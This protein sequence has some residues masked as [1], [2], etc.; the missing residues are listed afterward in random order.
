MKNYI[1][2]LLLSILL[3]GCGNLFVSPV[4]ETPQVPA[5]ENS[6]VVTFNLG[7][8][9]EG[10]LAHTLLPDMSFSKYVLSFTALEEGKQPQEDLELEQGSSSRSVVLQTG[11]WRVRATGFNG[12]TPVA[13]GE[14]DINVAYS[15]YS[16][17][18]YI[19]V[20]QPL[21][22]QGTFTYSLVHGTGVSVSGQL[23]KFDGTGDPQVL[24]ESGTINP[25][26]AGMYKLDV[27]ANNGEKEVARTELVYIYKDVNT[28]A[29][30]VFSKAEFGATLYIGGTLAINGAGAYTGAAL[31]IWGD[32]AYTKSL[33][34]ATIT[35]TTW[36]KDLPTLNG[37]S[38]LYF[39][40][41]ITDAGGDFYANAG[42]IPAPVDDKNDIPLSVNYIVLSGTLDADYTVTAYEIYLYNADFSQRF[43]KAAVKSDGTWE[44][45]KQAFGESTACW[46]V[47]GTTQ[48]YSGGGYFYDSKVSRDV[49]AANISGI[50]L[51]IEP[52]DTVGVNGAWTDI[53]VPSNS[54]VFYRIVPENSGK[55]TLDIQYGN[56]GGSLTLYDGITHSYM[57]ALTGDSFYEHVVEKDHPYVVCA[58]S[59]GPFNGDDARFKLRFV[60]RKWVNLKGAAVV[61][62]DGQAP[63]SAEVEVYNAFTNALL[64][65]GPAAGGNWSARVLER[66]AE[67]PLYFVVRA[68]DS[69]G[70]EFAKKLEDS[71]YAVY[72][73][74]PGDIDF[75]NVAFDAIAL[76]GTV[77]PVTV[78]LALFNGAKII[79]KSGDTIL[80]TGGFI[81]ESASN[82]WSIKIPP[83]QSGTELNFE[84]S[85]SYSGYSRT[86][87]F[88]NTLIG[89]TTAGSSN[90]PGINL[91]IPIVGINQTI[92]RDIGNYNGF[93]HLL[94]PSES[95]TLILETRTS[96]YFY[97]D[98]YLYDGT[99]AS[100]LGH[101]EGDA[102]TKGNV[103]IE[104]DVTANHPYIAIGRHNYSDTS[105]TVNFSSR[106]KPD[107]EVSI[108]G[109]SSSGSVVVKVF[110]GSIAEDYD[111]VTLIAAG[112]GTA[113]GG[114]A[115]V[116]LTKISDITDGQYAVLVTSGF[117]VRYADNVSFTG[118]NAAIAWGNLDDAS[119]IVGGGG[120]GEGY[121]GFSDGL[122]SGTFAVWVC[123]GT[124]TDYLSAALAMSSYVAV[125]ASTSVTDGKVNLMT[126]TA[127]GGTFNP[128]GTYTVIIGDTATMTTAGL[129]YQSGVS[130]SGGEATISYGGMT[131]VTLSY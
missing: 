130:F 116:S 31:E 124:V 1:S 118:G 98:M 80:G 129:K 39:R 8:S 45:K 43:A 4:N 2:V 106:Y 79:A 108:T 71:S 52:V 54:T 60:F 35:G 13:Y 102:A 87:T 111:S 51:T 5:G 127:T 93:W 72:D 76:T 122:P 48:Y 97:M 28:R 61:T 125:G 3:A 81:P 63:A 83:Q 20:A 49:F 57:Y 33:G 24:G 15:P 99:D 107:G 21:E 12:T 121:L 96:G 56:V 30:Y 82:E 62:I 25:I 18:V 120:I 50:E 58:S 128:N 11:D 64:G 46:L 55:V 44:L 70:T 59:T 113:S 40:V 69:G 123:S 68:I 86:Y 109:L 88:Y 38:K 23:K 19:G 53:L 34:S 6:S 47:P 9:P 27:S 115:L 22:G 110:T 36:A 85:F 84:V 41:K 101:V 77:S 91:S 37:A 126:L 89:G 94:R 74:N 131:T 65:E 7:T 112:T 114:E 17:S 67:T 32:Q 119:S 14:K 103:K 42:H 29:D 73:E 78:K 92:S 75:G 90:V 16:Q 100:Q 95:D 66:T 105:A 10:A 26:A 117:A 104:H